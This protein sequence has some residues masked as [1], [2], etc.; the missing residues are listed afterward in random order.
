MK[1]KKKVL[2]YKE[3]LFQD[4]K[5]LWAEC[6]KARAG[7]KSEYSGKWGKQIGGEEVLNAHH[8]AGKSCYALRFWIEGGMCLT[9]GEHNFIAH[10]S[11]RAE[12]FREF[13]KTKR[14]KDF[15]DKAKIMK[16][17]G[18]PTPLELTKIYLQQ[19]LKKYGMMEVS[20]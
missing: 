15:F 14:G 17:H 18:K 16:R 11:G 8:L 4:C 9:K 20:E 6:V 10:H 13:V 19:E 1:N 3:K 5:D 2:T 12:K 7:Y